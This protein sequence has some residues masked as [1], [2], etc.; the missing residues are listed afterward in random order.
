MEGAFSA[1]AVVSG[2]TD[3]VRVDGDFSSQ[4]VRFHDHAIGPTALTLKLVGRDLS[5]KGD[6]ISG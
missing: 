6:V 1:K 3:L 5:F 4:D 2:D